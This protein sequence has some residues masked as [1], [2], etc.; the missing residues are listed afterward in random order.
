M[1][2][3]FMEKINIDA[4]DASIGNI[5]TMPTSNFRINAKQFFLTYPK[6]DIKKEDFL[7]L[8]PNN[9]SIVEYC[10]AEEKHEDGSPHLHA[11]LKYSY[12]LNITNNGHFD[13]NG[14]H[15][16]IQSVKSWKNSLAYICKDG[17]FI[18]NT[19]LDKS[20]PEGYAR[21]K[22]DYEL[23]LEDTSLVATKDIVYP[24]KFFN[25]MIEKPLPEVK[26][27][28]FWF[29]GKPDIGKTFE[30]EKSFEDMKI[31]KRGNNK[32]P[33]ESY[34]DEDIIIYDDIDKI[35]FAE[36]SAIS[37]TYK[38]NTQVYGDVRYK[39]KYWKKNHCRTIIILSNFE[40][41]YGDN[42][43]GIDSRFEVIHLSSSQTDT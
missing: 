27:R 21:R 31:Y 24:V 33:F 7:T 5:N 17:N 38:T 41:N 18:G 26:K 20:S 35:S 14:F 34:R 42:Q 28:H 19:I 8:C 12:K 2:D 10:I 37:N 16:N 29:V 1:I 39:N 22:K 23:W 4:K 40:P 25:K 36:I 9:K 15:P 3:I 43:G 6:C 30:I 11:I 13:I 32:Y